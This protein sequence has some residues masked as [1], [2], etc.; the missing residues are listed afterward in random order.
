VWR[1][2]LFQ[3]TTQ[4]EIETLFARYD[5]DGNGT[6]EHAEF[7]EILGELCGDVYSTDELRMLFERLD[8]DGDR[9]VHDRDHS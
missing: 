4:A 6:I 3:T 1:S 5:S 2:F 8:R 7:V 9:C